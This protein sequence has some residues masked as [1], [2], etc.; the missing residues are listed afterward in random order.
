MKLARRAALITGAS[1]GLGA[2]IAEHLVRE[3]AS[4]ALCARGE[5]ALKDVEKK[6]TPL[7]APGAKI[8]AAT[9]DVG[10]ETQMDAFIANA[11]KIFPEL[12]ILVNNAGIY[13]PFGLL[14]EANWDEWADA[15]RINVLGTVYPCRK[16]VPHM[17]QKKYGK[18][19]N[20][21]GGGA[22]KPL[23]RISAYAASKA[24]V[25][26]FTETLAVEVKDFG[27]DVNAIAPGTLATRLNQDLVKAGPD[28]VGKEFHAQMSKIMNEGGTP[29][30][31]AAALVVWLAS[32]ES[33]GISGRLL[34]A[35][36]DNWQNLAHRKTEL[37]TS[38]IYTLRRITTKDRG[39]DW[40][41]PD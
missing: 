28:V 37:E 9:A 10:D 31:T 6:L 39:K 7:L 15:M 13:G 34:S 35:L 41:D 8:Y 19:I 5:K 1:H 2:E 3:G 36:W 11:L 32:K 12:D 33:D 30:A 14:E 29:L 25:V 22:T 27:I 26:R 16:L 23:P 17:K 40:G 38:D 20:I 24:A 18:I 21:S 4:V